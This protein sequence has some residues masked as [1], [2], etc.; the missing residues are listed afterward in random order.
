MESRTVY[1]T[2]D[3][4][5]DVFGGCS[6]SKP[7]VSNNDLSA[8][9]LEIFMQVILSQAFTTGPLPIMS[10]NARITCMNVLAASNT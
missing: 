7:D 6:S 1:R 2:L 8:S 5:G 3:R 10:P 9:L 4:D